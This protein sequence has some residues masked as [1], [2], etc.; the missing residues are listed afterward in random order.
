MTVES[1]FIHSQLDQEPVTFS[2]ADMQDGG[3]ISFALNLSVECLARG[4]A[5]NIPNDEEVARRRIVRVLEAIPSARIGIYKI[6]PGGSELNPVVHPFQQVVGAGGSVP[7]LIA[8]LDQQKLDL[9]SPE[10]QRFWAPQ[11]DRNA[12]GA[13]TSSAGAGDR[14]RA[15]QSWDAPVAHDMGLTR[16][17]RVAKEDAGVRIVALPFFH[18]GDLPEKLEDFTPLFGEADGVLEIKYD[19]FGD[20]RKWL[21]R[22][23]AVLA[24]ATKTCNQFGVDGLSPDGFLIVNEN[25]ARVHRLTRWFEERATSLLATHL[26]LAPRDGGEDETK[27]LARLCQPEIVSHI[28]NGQ[29]VIDGYRL[30]GGSWYAATRLLGALDNLVIAIMQPGGEQTE[31]DILAPFISQIIDELEGLRTETAGPTDAQISPT[32]LLEAIRQV[33][34]A[35]SPLVAS[36]TAGS[37]QKLALMEALAHAHG[38][39]KPT[40]ASP[41]IADDAHLAGSILGHVQIGAVDGFVEERLKVWI[42]NAL[43]DKTSVGEKVARCVETF[44]QKLQDEAGVEPAVLRILETVDL[45]P[46][47]HVGPWTPSPF[48]VFASKYVELLKP[49]GE[50]AAAIPGA[51]ERAWILYRGLLEGSFNGAEAVRRAAGVCFSRALL[52]AGGHDP[53]AIVASLKSSEFPRRRLLPDNPDTADCFQP[54]RVALVSI[55]GAWM[56]AAFR[57]AWQSHLTLTFADA[58]DTVDALISPEIFIPDRFPQS[59]PIQIAA[60]IDGAQTDEFGKAFNGI[61]LAVRRIDTKGAPFAHAHLADLAWQWPRPKPANPPLPLPIRAKAVLDPTLPTVADG[62]GP[63]FIEY[64]GFPL[65]SS[66][67]DVRE[68]VSGDHELDPTHPFYVAAAHKHSGSGFVATPRL[69]YGRKFE[70]FCFVTSNAGTLPI[71]VQGQKLPWLPKVLDGVAPTHHVTKVDYQRTTLISDMKVEDISKLLGASIAGVSPLADDYPRVILCAPKNGAATHDLF[72]IGSGGT[73]Y[74]PIDP[75]KTFQAEIADIHFAGAPKTLALQLHDRVGETPAWETNIDLGSIEPDNSLRLL[76]R[77]VVPP[78][79]SGAPAGRCLYINGKPNSLPTWLGDICWMRLKLAASK[80]NG[81]TMSFAA[82]DVPG[83]SADGA[84]VVL[85]PE[86]EVKKPPVPLVWKPGLPNSAAM[87]IST[88]RVT[89]LDF[90]RWYANPDERPARPDSFHKML[91]TAYLMRHLDTKLAAL[92]DRLPDPAVEALRLDLMIVDSLIGSNELPL[93]AVQQFDVWWTAFLKDFAAIETKLR[94]DTANAEPTPW[95]PETL[96]EVLRKLDETFR[97]DFTVKVGAK[98]DLSNGPTPFIATAPSGTVSRLALHSHVP[99]RHF[100]PSEGPKPDKL[101]YPAMLDERMAGY[102]ARID[103]SAVASFAGPSFR[104]EIMYNGL[105]DRKVAEALANRLIAVEPHERSRQY[106]LVSACKRADTE[107][108]RWRLIKEVDVVSQRWRPSGRPIYDFIAPRDFIDQVWQGDYEKKTGRLPDPIA[109]PLQVRHIGGGRD[110]SAFEHQ[111][112]F[113]RPDIDADSVTQKLESVPSR[114]VLQTF[115]WE[116][117]SATYLRHRFILRSRYAGALSSQDRREVATW[118]AEQSNSFQRTLGWTKRVALLADASRVLATRPQLRALLPLTTAPDDGET[119]RP[120]PPV[121]AILQEPPFARGGLAD[122]IACEIKTGF[123]YGFEKEQ[124]EPGDPDQ[125]AEPVQILDSRKEVGPTAHL[126]YRALGEETALGMTLLPEGPLGLTFDMVNAP[127]PAFPNSMITLR[128]TTWFGKEPPLEEMMMAV[129]MRRYIDPDWAVSQTVSPQTSEILELDPQRAWIIAITPTLDGPAGVTILSNGEVSMPLMTVEVGKRPFITVRAHKLPIDGVDTT[130]RPVT[131]AR[132]ESAHVGQLFLLHQP[133]APDRFAIAVLAKPKGTDVSTGRGD[134]PVVLAGFE[135]SLPKD[136]DSAGRTR[137]D[138]VKNIIVDARLNPVARETVVSAATQ[139]RWT[140]TG[141]DFEYVNL[142]VIEKDEWTSDPQPVSGLRALLENKNTLTITRG[143]SKQNTTWLCSSTF[144]SK[145]PLHVHRHVAVITSYFLNELGRPVERYLRTNASGD[146][147]MTLPKGS[148]ELPV[149]QACRIVE[150]E[151][152]AAI[153]CGTD[154]KGIPATYRSAYF[155]LFSTGFKRGANSRLRFFCRFVGPIPLLKQFKVLNL[156]LWPV[157]GLEPEKPSTLN[158]PTPTAKDGFAVGLH[159]LLDPG[160]GDISFAFLM[161]NGSRQPGPSYKK[162]ITLGEVNRDN[163]GL[164]M[165]IDAEPSTVE[166]WTD[167]SLLHS[168][169]KADG[170][171]FDFD[172]LF[173]PTGDGVGATSVNPI[174]LNTMAEAQARIVSISP[175]IPIVS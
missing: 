106:S 126:G 60:N 54:I 43:P 47:D 154:I 9:L 169:G 64:E 37:A 108:N 123:G 53:D 20:G 122:R 166:F 112:F 29:V 50:L 40:K 171:A 46:K 5:D 52:N 30:Q 173:S 153:L 116:A 145:V 59:L 97:I 148:N 32:M 16:I 82:F 103:A 2:L 66:F 111:A 140:R 130:E 28:E 86:N 80:E 94:K 23:A 133:I 167:I 157:A 101:R 72:K 1:T 58:L 156:K 121:A 18:E 79:D 48:R 56:P 26:A 98:L 83:G 78:G 95:T 44:E 10:R 144:K 45:P 141:R 127:A 75:S 65:A 27:K 128:P 76:F 31:G 71:A 49:N 113:D 174:K 164:V 170:S 151:T 85:A 142:A 146:K 36:P 19:P 124:P 17:L 51:F 109:L 91:L 99:A 41:P 137:D 11:A 125:D 135:W 150:Y 24:D 147:Q 6:A 114:T 152:P 67:T 93:S 13:G 15:M 132:V 110:L 104:F 39:V 139:H 55:D 8:W 61:A 38:I 115:P 88:P 160:A 4:P 163:P 172:W 73:I 119:R 57:T 117:P 7:E 168:V 77:S 165:T 62:R 134:M 120:A 149:D 92:I 25:A 70:A 34:K 69:A 14:L 131:I 3:P 74:I 96:I 129:A 89:Y 159:V 105:A 138:A 12:D 155:D 81:A 22:A 143:A 136:R 42:A 63:M 102:A 161:S 158:I 35:K 84:L 33:L 68:A 21:C 175:P 107:A 90:E 162:E 100:H 118:P 87:R